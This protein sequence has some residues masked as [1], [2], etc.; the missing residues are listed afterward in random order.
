MA[1]LSE[2]VADDI[3]RRK[4]IGT[5]L[6][7]ISVAVIE[8][9]VSDLQHRAERFI[10]QFYYDYPFDD[11]PDYFMNVASLRKMIQGHLRRY[12]ASQ[13]DPAAD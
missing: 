1:W 11:D 7:E 8:S 10:E 12:M 13:N 3:I 9:P 2:Q 4:P 5:S 6:E